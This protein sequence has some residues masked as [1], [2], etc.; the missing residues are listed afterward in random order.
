MK[1]RP[2]VAVDLRALVGTPTGIGT[3]TEALLRRLLADGGVSWIGLSHRPAGAAGHLADLGLALEHQA[4]PLG[5]LW[6]QLRLPRRLARGDIDLF[7]SPL[8]VLPLRLPVPGVVTVHDLTPLLLPE[9]HHWKT[10]WSFRPFLRATLSRARRVVADSESTANDLR[11]FEPGCARRLEVVHPGV[12]EHFR[13][14]DAESVARV[15]AELG[16]PDGYVL[17]AGTLE[18]RK[19]LSTL[20]DAWSSLGRDALGGLPLL[21][22]G[23]YGWGSR[24]L[25][26]RIGSLRERNVRYLGWLERHRM[27]QVL[28]AA[29]VFVYPSLYEGFGLPVLEAMACGVPVVTTNVSSLNEVAGDAALRVN[30]TDATAWAEAVRSLV[31]GAGLA[32]QLA[33]DGRDRSLGF[34]WEAAAARMAT[35]F[36]AVLDEI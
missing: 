28:Q 15:R 10:R 13:P 19:N 27:I 11:R 7:W 16:C 24:D 8:S 2:T 36:D 26:D 20:L 23:P 5:V 33:V 4:A 22:I 17:Y 3:F 31:E 34:T 21:L 9:M 14:A 6:Q 25:L 35:I 30:P 1:Q 32:S 29:R 12:D 18:P